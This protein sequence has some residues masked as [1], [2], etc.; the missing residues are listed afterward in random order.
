MCHLCGA[1]LVLLNVSDH[2]T[3]S[4][5]NA[6]DSSSGGS[7]RVLGCLLGVQVHSHPTSAAHGMPSERVSPGNSCCRLM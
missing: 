3:R 1:Q 5:A 4:R 2:Y 7:F 6:V